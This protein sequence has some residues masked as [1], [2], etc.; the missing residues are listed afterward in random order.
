MYAVEK[1][2][3]QMTERHV[4]FDQVN[5]L[6]GRIRLGSQWISCGR[7]G[8]SGR[9]L[10]TTALRRHA[11]VAWPVGQRW[12]SRGQQICR[13]TSANQRSVHNPQALLLL[14]PEISSYFVE[15]ADE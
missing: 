3:Q 6:I 15:E 4:I 14:R 5:E 2:K 12:T 8:T 10:G 7:L 11:P 9:S 1:I 13:L